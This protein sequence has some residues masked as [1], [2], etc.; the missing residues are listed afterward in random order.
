MSFPQN[1]NTKAGIDKRLFA[2]LFFS[3]ILATIIGTLL[4]ELGHFAVAKYFGYDAHISYDR[5]SWRLIN[6]PGVNISQHRL[7]MIAG[8][9]MQTI[10]T[11]TI[12]MVLLL[13]NYRS[14][15]TAHRL[16]YWQWIQVFFSLFWLR[17]IANGLFWLAGYLING[18]FS[19]RMDEIRLAERLQLPAWLFVVTTGIAGMIV[20]IVVLKWFIPKNQLTSFIAA[21]LMG[22]ITGYPLW[23]ELIGK[24]IL[25]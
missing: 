25:P 9:P 18:R 14:F 21:G 5:T 23:F 15:A 3:F 22:S 20:L 13:I 8:G 19:S 7:L 12:G 10:L 1:V 4:H 16:S 11:G 17:Q 24:Y 2:G 6:E